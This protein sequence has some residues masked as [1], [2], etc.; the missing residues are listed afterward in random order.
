VHRRGSSF[1]ARNRTVLAKLLT[2]VEAP[3]LLWS[4]RPG[5]DANLARP[6]SIYL[7]M[8]TLNENSD[9][10]QSEP[11]RHVERLRK[12]ASQTQQS[13]VQTL[14]VI[15]ETRRLIGLLEK[16]DHPVIRAARLG[17]EVEPARRE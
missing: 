7:A 1:Q 15:D 6:A 4:F 10:R 8:E 3:H 14:A 11:R 16:M 5:Q 13:I 2:R 9:G 12:V 17:N